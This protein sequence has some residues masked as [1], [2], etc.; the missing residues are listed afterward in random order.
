LTGNRKI[1]LA[2]SSPRRRDLLSKVLVDF[3][4]RPAEI[5]ESLTGDTPPAIARSLAFSKA[6]LVARDEP[7][8]L[9]IGADTI[10]VVDHVVLGKPS[11]EIDAERMLAMISGRVH[12]VVTGVAI[13]DTSSGHHMVEHEES[14]VHI[15]ALSAE[16]VKAYV[17]TGEPMDKA[18][19]YAVQG[20]GSVIVD[21]IE[22]D[23]FNVVGLPMARLAKMLESF[24]VHILA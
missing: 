1:V 8:S 7:D 21:R 10:V 4:V 2:S 18:G 19:A 6:S 5:D 11:D 17:R 9:V 13:I 24:D 16:Q 12:M 20:V 15:R 14:L 22:G 3:K 23:Y